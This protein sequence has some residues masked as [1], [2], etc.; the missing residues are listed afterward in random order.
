MP[1]R[2]ANVLSPTDAAYLA[3]VIDGEGCFAVSLSSNHIYAALELAGCEQAFIQSLCALAG[4]GAVARTPFRKPPFRQSYR[5]RVSLKS[6]M[7]LIEQVLPFLK[8]KHPQAVLFLQL[9]SFQPT[10]V[11]H[12]PQQRDLIN[13][14]QHL[15]VRGC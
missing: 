14:I 10:S 1:T 12:S 3:G 8:L 9:S 5:W 2:K 6:S 4:T 13:R 15:N 11:L 7:F